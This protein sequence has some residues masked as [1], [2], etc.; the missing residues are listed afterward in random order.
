[1]LRAVTLE[2][3]RQGLTKSAFGLVVFPLF[4]IGVGETHDALRV[5][6]VL[7]AEDT[8]SD[9][10]GLEKQWLCFLDGTAVA[11][12]RGECGDARRGEGVI[13]AQLLSANR[14]TLAQ[15]GLGLVESILCSADLRRV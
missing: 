2:V 9:R 5:V 1:M 7:L 12:E 3:D 4:L 15:H 6:G 10:E 8:A 13:G 11:Q 14:Q